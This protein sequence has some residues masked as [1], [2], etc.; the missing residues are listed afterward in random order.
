[1]RGIINLIREASDLGE[2]AIHDSSF[3]FGDWVK[4]KVKDKNDAIGLV[5]VV[6]V[7]MVKFNYLNENNQ[8]HWI[9]CKANQLL[10]PSKE[11]IEIEKRRYGI[12]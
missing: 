5:E 11:E 4:A 8:W 3:K 9:S 2:H 6:S 7:D 12:S 10:I 1:M